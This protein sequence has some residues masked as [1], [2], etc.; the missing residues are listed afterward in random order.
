[1]REISHA[2]EAG[3]DVRLGTRGIHD[4][5]FTPTV[6]D[7]AVRVGKIIGDIS[8]EFLAARFVAI[9]RGIHISHWRTVRRFGLRRVENA[10]LK[11]ERPTRIQDKTV[12]GVMGIGRSDAAQNAFLEIGFAI[13]VSI[14]HE[15]EVRGLGHNTPPL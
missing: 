1:M 9:N 7:M 8:F 14:L 10:L 3:P 11:I 12:R 2:R 13:A 15:H 6:E 4:E 5:I